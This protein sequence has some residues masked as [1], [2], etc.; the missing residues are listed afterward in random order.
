MLSEK[1]SVCTSISSKVL[2][3][4]GAEAGKTHLMR[5]W[6]SHSDPSAHHNNVYVPTRGI[7]Y[8]QQLIFEIVNSTAGVTEVVI[9]P[10]EIGSGLRQAYLSN[11][12]PIAASA[13]ILCFNS[14]KRSTYVAMWTKWWTRAIEWVLE[15]QEK[16]KCR[17]F[18][19][20]CDTAAHATAEKREESRRW[21]E[22][23]ILKAM[24]AHSYL[25]FSIDV[26]SA[27]EVHVR[28]TWHKVASQVVTQN[29]TEKMEMRLR[30]S[31]AAAHG[32]HMD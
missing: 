30:K 19:V 1:K 10:E 16:L 7:I 4:G 6:I 21:I 23:D 26:S 13:Y 5:H 15:A 24:V 22:K 25:F 12:P 31:H 32:S 14:R 3:L 11:R 27:T 28:D 29:H 2:L 20:F 18:I 8:H 17:P 9:S